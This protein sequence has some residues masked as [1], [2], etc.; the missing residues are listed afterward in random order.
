[1]V[2]NIDNAPVDRWFLMSNIG[3]YQGRV[4][5][6]RPSAYLPCGPYRIYGYKFRPLIERQA[7]TA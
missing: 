2:P 3:I 5:L 7:A 4:N 1:M 6:T